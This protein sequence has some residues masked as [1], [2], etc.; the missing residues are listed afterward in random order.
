ML[1]IVLC[2]F[3]LAACTI[4]RE[5][6][7]PSDVSRG[8]TGLVFNGVRFPNEAELSSTPLRDLVQLRPPKRGNAKAEKHFAKLFSRHPLVKDI[9]LDTMTE[10][11]YIRHWLD[12]WDKESA[13]PSSQKLPRSIL[14]HL[15]RE[16]VDPRIVSE[17][18]RRHF[19]LA[20]RGVH[21][22]MRDRRRKTTDEIEVA[23]RQRDLERRKKYNRENRIA[24]S[25][26]HLTQRN[27]DEFKALLIQE[28]IPFDMAATEIEERTRHLADVLGGSQHTTVCLRSFLQRRDP[29]DVNLNLAVD[30]RKEFNFSRTRQKWNDIKKWRKMMS[31]GNHV[32]PGTRGQQSNGGVATLVQNSLPRL[33]R[34]S[35]W[36]L[37]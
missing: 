15:E 19:L 17:I 32:I 22:R 7:L 25:Y 34:L 30:N 18:K 29:N 24:Q 31:E 1:L 36:W 26:G 4:I 2:L 23:K 12:I 13:G 3:G 20:D 16:R 28:S 10:E 11:E 35:K 21:S 8:W 37:S 33:L 9:S 5:E 14:S 6:A 27:A